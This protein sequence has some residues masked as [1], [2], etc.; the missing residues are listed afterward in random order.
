M[1]ARYVGKWD[2]LEDTGKNG[3]E[4]AQALTTYRFN[5]RL[6]DAWCDPRTGAVGRQ[7]PQ[8]PS[9]WVLGF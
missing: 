7:T 1:R 2:L 8:G 6:N 5:R 3:R 4:A 9:G